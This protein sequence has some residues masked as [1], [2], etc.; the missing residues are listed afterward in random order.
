MIKTKIPVYWESWLIVA[1]SIL[2]AIVLRVAWA[3]RAVL[4]GGVRFWEVDSYYHADAVRQILAGGNTDGA[5]LYDR[6]LARVAGMF[7]GSWEAALTVTPLLAHSVTA[8]LLYITARRMFGRGPAAI[9]SV[10]FA[11]MPGEYLGRTM[12]G[13]I[14]YHSCEVMLVMGVACLGTLAITTKSVKGAGLYGLGALAVFAAYA[15]LWRGWPIFTLV[16]IGAL[17]LY[18]ARLTAVTPWARAGVVSVLLLLAAFGSFVLGRLGGV[19]PLTWEATIEAVPLLAPPYP[20]YSSIVVVITL[21]GSAGAYLTYKNGGEPKYAFWFS[22]VAVV[23]VATFFQRRFAYYL[24]APAAAYIGWLVIYTLRDFKGSPKYGLVATAIATAIA[25]AMLP[26]AIMVASTPLYSPSYAWEGALEWTREHTPEDA[27]VVAWW[28]HGYWVRYIAEREPMA[29][30]SQD[31]REV[32]A[33]AGILTTPE[34]GEIPVGAYIVLDEKTMLRGY[35]SVTEWAGYDPG[36]ES[37]ARRLWDGETIDG[38]TLKYY[39][40]EVRIYHY[41]S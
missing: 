29:D 20:V 9:A 39:T 8:V 16:P 26:A 35:E 4:G 28:D 13:N 21:F 1:G 6:L 27:V 33:V 40:E 37:V 30:N 25:G 23:I 2:A 15:A 14:D 32:Q 34:P 11:V 41:G 19:D 10:V 22:F 12:F 38:I 17:G 36:G 31:R 24:A 7:P 3:G 18:T 5:L